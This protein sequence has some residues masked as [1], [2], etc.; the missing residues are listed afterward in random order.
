M[1]LLM[2]LR[3]SYPKKSTFSESHDSEIYQARMEEKK[4]ADV[5]DLG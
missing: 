4:T 1:R 5:L 2:S 3:C